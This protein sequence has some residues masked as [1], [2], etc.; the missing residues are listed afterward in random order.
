MDA[1]GEGGGR[2]RVEAGSAQCCSKPESLYRPVPFVYPTC[3]NLCELNGKLNWV[4]AWSCTGRGAQMDLLHSFITSHKRAKTLVFLSS[5]KQ[6]CT[7]TPALVPP[8][9]CAL[10]PLSLPCSIFS[11]VACPDDDSECICSIL[12]QNSGGALSNNVSPCARCWAV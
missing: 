6:A 5:C 3:R 9:S 8:I 11:P 7:R 10:F 12:A 2:G 1:P 4:G